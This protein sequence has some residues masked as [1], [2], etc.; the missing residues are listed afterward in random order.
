MSNRPPWA[1]NMHESSEAI[2]V[3]VSPPPQPPPPPPQPQPQAIDV[4][5]TP[6]GERHAE[7]NCLKWIISDVNKQE[8]PC[9]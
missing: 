6:T 8:T 7:Y 9:R 1:L 2:T 3:H 4:L 5:K